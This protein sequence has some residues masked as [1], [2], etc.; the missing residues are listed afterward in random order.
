MG[1]ENLN[2]SAQIPLFRVGSEAFVGHQCLSEL[3]HVLSGQGTLQAVR[4]VQPQL[5]DKFVNELRHKH[6]HVVLE[7]FR[8]HL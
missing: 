8:A 7:V 6:F 2:K 3:D 4:N 5:D 1:M